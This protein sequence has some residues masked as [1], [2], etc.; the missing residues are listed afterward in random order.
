[1]KVR[2]PCQRV[3]LHITV[4]TFL[5]LA[6]AVNAFPEQLPIRAY[7]TVDGLARDQINTIMQDSRGFIWFGTDEGVSRFDGYQFV[8]YGVKDGLPDRAVSALL[9][10]R[11]GTYWIGTWGGL[12]YFRP[13]DRAAAGGRLGLTTL[14]LDEQPPK[15]IVALLQDP[16]GGIW[17]GTSDGLY[18]IDQVD[19]AWSPTRIDIGLERV[20]A[21]VRRIYAMVLDQQSTLWIGTESGLFR[22]TREGRA[23]HYTTA[24]GLPHNTIT[25][26]TVDEKEHLWLGAVGAICILKTESE[27]LDLVAK[28][29]FSR[30]NGYPI[31]FLS[32]FRT[33]D[34]RI[35]G[36]FEDGL[37]L[38]QQLPAGEVKT[39]RY[40]TAQGLVHNSV[41]N[42]FEDRD[43]NLWVGTESAG[44]MK[45]AR[46]GFTTFREADGLSAT[47]ISSLFENSAG[48]LCVMGGMYKRGWKPLN[49][50]D[51]VRFNSH[52]FQ[53]PLGVNSTWG[54]YQTVFQDHAGDWWI[55]SDKGSYRFPQAANSS[56]PGPQPRAVYSIREG[57]PT[58]E[59]FRQYE[60]R[61]GDVWFSTMGNPNATLARWSRTENKIRV[62]TAQADGILTAAPTAFMA[63]ATGNLWIGF[64]EGGLYRYR[65]GRFTPFSKQDG[66]PEGLVRALYLDQKKRLWIGTSRGGVARIDDPTAEHPQ[67]HVLTMA[68]GLASDQITCITE[69]N[70]GRIYVGTG[71]GIDRLDPATER[72]RHYGIADGLPD[73]FINVSLRDRHGSLWFGTLRG[74]ARLNP[75][76][77]VPRQPPPIMINK[78]RAG[79]AERTLA[80][81]GAA[82][83]NGIELGPN[84]NNIQ[85]EFASVSF[86]PGESLRYEY[87]LEGADRAWSQPT[88]QRFVNFANLAPGRYRFLVRAINSDGLASSRPA[89]ISFR[90]LPPVWLRWWFL[91]AVILVL[92]LLVF[93]FARYRASHVNER[94]RVEVALLRSRE[95]R[96][97][98]LEQVRKR[99]ASDLHDDIGSSLTQISLLS[100]V[101]QQQLGQKE[102]AV[103]QPLQSIAS[104]S[105]ELVDTLTDIVWAI[106]PKKDHLSDLV[107]RMRSYASET[108]LA[109]NIKVNFSG[110]AGGTD[111]RL[112][113]NLRREVFLVFK[114]SVNNIV[115][116]SGASAAMID[117]TLNRNELNLQIQDDGCG[118]D[119]GE[120]TDGHGLTSIRMRSQDIGAVLDVSSARDCGTTITLRVPLSELLM[121][122]QPQRRV[123]TRLRRITGPLR[124]QP[125]KS[126]NDQQT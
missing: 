43:G 70:W 19:G 63:D 80:E 79:G 54:W 22:R 89:T 34:G 31:R 71:N 78:L 69:D 84:E 29:S 7:T 4:L 102:P 52:G 72:I 118:F 24:E 83:I 94:K 59:I 67:F 35:W 13:G 51:G 41:N 50:F 61:Y 85:A 114:E 23:T 64:Y 96:L 124:R 30:P 58:N 62:Y 74:L 27:T 18:R 106:N 93:A 100:E 87:M 1:M 107:K 92:G 8:N 75:R 49:V 81:L 120:E 122:L 21:E 37:N 55:N 105:R 108:L 109:A 110:P 6:F 32:L 14:A 26:L 104:S 33:S 125:E 60:D 112:G 123:G 53:L 57:M 103:T 111:T 65:D 77:D 47:R 76:E 10:S 2:P 48:E 46:E 28:Q 56:L 117:F 68:N 73:N 45:I 15:S 16:Q 20:P 17:C 9:E 126:P 12:S 39:T 82:E 88:L 44:V 91:I 42:L 3:S 119:D 115:R 25:A 99:I 113:A 98:E 97:A 38:L 36:S 40:T 66:L 90:V 101:V 5:I 121:D 95:E 11:D 86:S 116:H